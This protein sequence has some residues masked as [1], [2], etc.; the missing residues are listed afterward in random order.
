M[1][2]YPRDLTEFEARF[3]TEEACREYLFRLRWPDGFRCPGCGCRKSWPLRSVLLQCAD[4][5][6]Q[7]SVTAGTILQDTRTSLQLWFRAMWWITTQKNGAS[8]LGL[9][10]VLGLRRYE[11]AWTWLHKLRRAMVRP[12]RDLLAGRVEVDESYLGGP[13]EGLRGRH[14]GTKTLIVIAAQEDGKGIGRIRMRRIGDASAESLLPFVEESIEPGS[15]VHT[16]G[17]LGYAPL[18]TRGYVHEI[19]FHRGRKKS[20]SE[21]MPRVHRVV[22]LLKRWLMG[23]HQGAVSHQHLDYYLDEFTFRFNRR[24]SRSRGK[25]FFRLAQQVVAVQPVPYEMLVR[26]RPKL[27]KPQHIG[28]T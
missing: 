3:S 22:S 23:T 8:A 27:A 17:W 25:L 2:D 12:G 24:K 20:P 9:Q 11:T 15:V 6:H 21:L 14:L 7:T 13:E 19:T 5:G 4:C 26:R 28:A 1:E 16:D 18:D 10:R